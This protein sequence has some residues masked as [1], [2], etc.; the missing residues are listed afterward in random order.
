MNPDRRHAFH[1]SVKLVFFVEVIV[2][3]TRDCA[4]SRPL[5]S[6]P[7]YHYRRSDSPIPCITD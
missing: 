5:S 4:S 2:G 6:Q 1:T 3:E 7:N